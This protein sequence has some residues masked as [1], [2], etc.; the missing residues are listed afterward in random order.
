MAFLCCI[1]KYTTFTFNFKA[2]VSSCYFITSGY[3]VRSSGLSLGVGVS[4]LGVELPSHSVATVESGVDLGEGGEE[5]GLLSNWRRV[6][7]W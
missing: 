4:E 1:F 6:G 7:L 3:E 5:L 2:K